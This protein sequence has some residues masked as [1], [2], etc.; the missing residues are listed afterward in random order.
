MFQRLLIPLAQVTA[1]NTSE[2]L[3]NEIRK[4]TYSLYRAKEITEKVYNDIM[5]SVKMIEYL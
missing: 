1:G 2:N 4:I 3:L 5:N